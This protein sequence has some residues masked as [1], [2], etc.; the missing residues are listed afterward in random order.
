[1]TGVGTVAG[2]AHDPGPLIGTGRDADVFDVGG[3]RVLRRSRAGRS[4]AD[5]AAVMVHVAGAGYPVPRVDDVLA[6]G[7]LVMER[8]D[9]P[10][11]L[12][13]LARRPWLARR[14]ARVLADLLARLHDIG[15]PASL[16]PA[17]VAGDAVVHLDL[18]PANVLMSPRG[19]V[20]IDWA[21]AARGA[22]AADVAVTW[23][24]CSAASPPAA[25]VLERTVLSAFQRR[26]AEAVVGRLDRAAAM[27]A[28]PAVAAWKTAHANLSADEVAAMRR[29]ARLGR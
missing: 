14:Y 19:P 4:L 26:F 24:V 28:V 15:A 17:P 12:D 16:R 23:L 9:G 27:A 6:D 25:G 2:V 5:E 21:N 8:V 1:M 20:V 13:D 10:S 11:M 22:P 7:S 18:H 3:G 29:L